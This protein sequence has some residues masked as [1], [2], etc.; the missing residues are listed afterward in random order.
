MRRMLAHRIC[1][2]GL[3]AVIIGCSSSAPAATGQSSGAGE[4]TT[5]PATAAATP[6]PTPQPVIAVVAADGG[7]DVRLPAGVVIH[8]DAATFPAGTEVRVSAVAL[9]P[10]GLAV[11]DLI[12]PTLRL[13]APS[14]PLQPLTVVFPISAANS[15]DLFA[16]VWNEAGAAEPLLAS[17]SG[18]TATVELPHL[19]LLSIVG[20]FGVGA[21]WLTDWFTNTISD[22]F[23]TPVACATSISGSPL[24][25]AAFNGH[26]V[27]DVGVTNTTNPWRVQLRI[28]NQRRAWFTYTITGACNQL[29][30]EYGGSAPPA[31][32]TRGRL[33]PR[34]TVGE[35][36][37]ISGQGD[38]ARVS[39]VANFTP[40]AR[41]LTAV[42]LIADV[43][44]GAST[45]LTAAKAAQTFA[46][47][48]AKLPEF[49][50]CVSRAAAFR[51]LVACVVKET[52][53]ALLT[54][55]VA[56]A[57][58]AALSPFIAILATAAPLV[59]YATEMDSIAGGGS[60]ELAR[61]V[62]GYTV[63][64]TVL[65]GRTGRVIASR[66]A[67]NLYYIITSQAEL[68]ANLSRNG[69]PGTAGM[70][71]GSVTASDD[72]SFVL[73]GIPAGMYLL[74]SSPKTQPI[75][76]GIGNLYWN[77]TSNCSAASVVRVSGDVSGLSLR[78]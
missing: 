37:D 66:V 69:A 38:G 78:Y 8:G 62:S 43:L 73:P 32:G 71:G 45:L 28:C 27:I 58:A 31:D 22:Y 68:C 21:S 53:I 75:R 6:S 4:A 50:L 51:D 42:Q 59:R 39:I 5:A 49:V 17:V 34:T 76:L 2:V 70:S 47:I 46:E 3:A 56:P 65:D 63:R 40:E 23:N 7:L 60:V 52:L 36:C 74:V 11:S 57:L 48:A 14:Q 13:D 19:S 26:N 54:R 10:R 12:A 61:R 55:L 20:L 15:A 1:A 29:M 18:G 35:P 9:A 77:G 64:G 41:V 33:P 67:V 24:T 30:G 72:G 44:P 25:M 16:I